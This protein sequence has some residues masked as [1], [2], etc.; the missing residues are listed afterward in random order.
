MVVIRAISVESSAQSCSDPSD[1][2]VRNQFSFSNDHSCLKACL[3][4]ILDWVIFRFLGL[5]EL[6]IFWDIAWGEAEAALLV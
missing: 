5:E 2:P 1:C 6:R 3:K 4:K